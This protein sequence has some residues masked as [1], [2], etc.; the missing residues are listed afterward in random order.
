MPVCSTP[1]RRPTRAPRGARPLSLFT[2]DT[3]VTPAGEGRY[4]ARIDPGW[5]IVRG[6][7]GGYL[8]A[9]VLRAMQDAVGDSSRLPRS[10]TVHFTAPPDEGEALVATTRERE[11]RSLTTV[12]ARLGQGGR[13]CALALCAF[14]RER[15]GPSFDHARMP[16]V[17]P[18]ERC[19]PRDPGDAGIALHQRY[20]Q[21]H[22]VGA[23]FGEAGAE[24]LSGGWIRLR[25]HE[26]PVDAPVLA[27]ITDAWPP[28]VFA[29]GRE[30]IPR[31]VPTVDLTVHFRAPYPAGA[32]PRD[33]VLAVFRSRLA[34]GGFVEE[35]GEVWSRD[36]TLLV[37]SRQLAVIA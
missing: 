28:A 36:G 37:Q 23:P 33:F 3:A 20:E 1:A 25:E 10:L 7:N 12:S 14:S 13:L 34:A 19:A 27:A 9:L 29:L 32:D 6:P 24:A 26:G 17:A 5:W 30:A 15:A 4:A 31:G 22:A 18:P 8:A 35:D 16:E 21:R 2:R 11:G